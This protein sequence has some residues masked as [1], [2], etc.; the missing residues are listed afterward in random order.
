M[1]EE[2]KLSDRDMAIEGYGQDY[3]GVL[4]D[5]TVTGVM[6]YDGRVFNHYVKTGCWSHRHEHWEQDY[7]ATPLRSA[8]EILATNVGHPAMKTDEVSYEG[9]YYSSQP[10]ESCKMSG[11]RYDYH[12]KQR[13]RRLV[14][15]GEVTLPAPAVFSKYGNIYIEAGYEEKV[16]D[17]F[18]NWAR[19]NSTQSHVKTKGGA[20]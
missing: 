12:D 17:L 1:N 14:L 19:S 13:F 3:K 4:P 18:W 2:D 16:R 15:Q 20:D 6:S 5:G 7:E 11:W 9:E 10:M 8:L